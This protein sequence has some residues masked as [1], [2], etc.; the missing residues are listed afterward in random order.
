[1]LVLVMKNVLAMLVFDYR[2]T[3]LFIGFICSF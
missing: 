3:V 2:L 1:M